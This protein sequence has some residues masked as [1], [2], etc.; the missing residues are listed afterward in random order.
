MNLTFMSVLVLLLLLCSCSMVVNSTRCISSLMILESM[1]LTML[2]AMLFFLNM[3]SSVQM[4]LLLLCIAVL[5]AAIGLS[6]LINIVRLSGNDLVKFMSS[7]Q[8]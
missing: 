7:A 5:E 2:V 4:I 8:I 6:V 3:T 1:T